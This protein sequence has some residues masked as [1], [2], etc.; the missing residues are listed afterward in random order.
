[1]AK[2]D[3]LETIEEWKKAL[4]DLLDQAGAAAARGEGVGDVQT[5]VLAYIKASPGK[6][7]FLD[8]IAVKA[9]NDLV[10]QEITRLVASIAARKQDIEAAMKTLNSATDGLRQSESDLKFEQIIATLQLSTAIVVEVKQLRA[11]LAD[12][13]KANLDKA[14]AAAKTASDIQKLVERFKVT[15]TG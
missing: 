1:M 12:D 15:V 5:D 2:F 3:E 8:K 11:D 14:I 13:D 10:E 7:N 9:A 6:C 4:Q